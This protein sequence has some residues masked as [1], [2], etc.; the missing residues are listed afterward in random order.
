MN[1]EFL[2][3]ITERKSIRSFDSSQ[4][5]D[6]SE[7][8]QMLQEA[9]RAPSAL[10]L[11]PWRFLVI[12][13]DEAKKKLRPLFFNDPKLLDSCAAMVAVLGDLQASEYKDTIYDMAVSE[14]LMPEEVRSRE[15]KLIASLYSSMPRDTRLTDVSF[16]SALAAMQL[17]LVAR[18]HGYETCPLGGFDKD[19]FGE[20]FGFN[21][22]RYLSLVLIAIGKPAEKGFESIRLDVEQISKW[23]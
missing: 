11:Q 15:V 2:K 21:K 22:E 18:A 16:N 5:I 9:G 10:N 8:K 12:E 20:A 4:K 19:H 13:S 17:M 3:V 7:M 23:V 14:G 6:R 1:G